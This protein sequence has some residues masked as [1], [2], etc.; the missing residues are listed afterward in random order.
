MVRFISVLVFLLIFLCKK[1]PSN[2]EPDGRYLRLSEMESEIKRA[3]KIP[4]REHLCSDADF[5]LFSCVLQNGKV[6]SLCVVNHLNGRWKVKYQFGSRSN[7]EMSYPELPQDFLNDFNVTA[8]YRGFGCENEGIA[9]TEIT[10]ENKT[11]AYTVFDR[12]YSCTEENTIGV[13]VELIKPRND[14]EII[15]TLKCASVSHSVLDS[16]QNG[17]QF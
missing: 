8:Y 4:R 3:H 17:K 2:L 1:L 13:E 15:T 11:Y 14:R 5:V 10:F 12:Y 9:Y 6:I 7:L 16:F